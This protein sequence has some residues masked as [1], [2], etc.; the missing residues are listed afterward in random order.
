MSDNFI[1]IIIIIIMI[2]ARVSRYAFIL[3]G[4]IIRSMNIMMMMMMMMVILLRSLLILS[5]QALIVKANHVISSL[6]EEI[7]LEFSFVEFSTRL[8]SGPEIFQV[9]K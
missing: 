5:K 1:I 4:I 8:L 7:S 3:P 2:R 9:D 6:D